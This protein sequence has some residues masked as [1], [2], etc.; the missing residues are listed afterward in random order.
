LRPGA[1]LLPGRAGHAAGIQVLVVRCG[2]EVLLARTCVTGSGERDPAARGSRPHDAVRRRLAICPLLGRALPGRAWAVAER[3]AVP[4]EVAMAGCGAD[5]AGGTGVPD[6][7]ICR[8]TW[9]PVAT[10]SLAAVTPAA[11]CSR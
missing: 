8:T 3:A 11:S 1:P 2:H 9:W 10:S 5:G 4:R 6:V 7:A